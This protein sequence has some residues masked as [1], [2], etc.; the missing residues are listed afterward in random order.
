MFSEYVNDEYKKRNMLDLK[1]PEIKEFHAICSYIKY[2]TSFHVM[3]VLVKVR[4]L[5]GGHGY[6]AYSL[7]PTLI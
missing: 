7:I 5:L 2:C 4:D 3:D 6:S 1:N